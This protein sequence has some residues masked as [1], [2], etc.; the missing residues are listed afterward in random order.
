MTK[1]RVYEVAKDLGMDNKAL[2]MYREGDATTG[3]KFNA[4][5]GITPP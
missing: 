5:A 2:G 3:Y 1:L 4:A